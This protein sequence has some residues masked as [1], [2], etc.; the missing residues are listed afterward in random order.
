MN[1]AI[2]TRFLLKGKLEGIGW[3]T[4]QTLKRIVTAHPEHQFYFL[5]DRQYDEAFIFSKNVH[6]VVVSPPARHPF[7]WYYWFEIALPKALKKI[8]AD[9]FVSTD[10]YL[11]LKSNVKSLVVIHDLA[12]EHYPQ[13]INLLTRLFYKYYTPKYAHHSDRIA[14]VSEY[15][16]NDIYEQYK[17]PKA[18]ID[19]VYNGSDPAF[20]PVENTVKRR[21]KAQ[22]TDGKPYFLF[23]G[24]IHPRKN[25]Q[26]LLEAFDIYKK[27]T[28]SDTKLLIVGRK[29]WN[30]KKIM[31]TY[32]NLTHKKE[33]LFIDHQELPEL[34]NITASADV[35][36]YPS[37]FEG[38]GIPII[39][40]MK[41]GTPVIT[42]KSSSM[43]EIA[44]SSG[45]LIDPNDPADIAQK[46]EIVITD[47]LVKN[48][49][50]NKG[51]K[52][53][54]DFSWDKTAESLWRSIEKIM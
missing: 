31:D 30:Y 36:V 33:V 43:R 3:F 42:S 40:A 1:I 24:S 49:L 27:N 8:N 21:I 45:L 13:H 34:V 44:E 14:T 41:C 26:T 4:Y 15:S 9:I 17:I 22:Y 32:Q 29:A 12:F 48:A 7:L 10:G 39:E 25:V 5:F 11:S 53:A 52:R 38:F 54:K 18:K 28:Q 35:M 16:K 23:V 19:V 46:M 51:F 6:P 37:L 47:E 20:K 50:I 2:N